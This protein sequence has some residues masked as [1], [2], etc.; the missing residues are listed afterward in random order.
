[1]L[2]NKKAQPP[3]KVQTKAKE[4]SLKKPSP[5]D[6]K[7]YIDYLCKEGLKYVQIKDEEEAAQIQALLREEVSKVLKSFDTQQDQPEKSPRHEE[8][9]ISKAILTESCTN[10]FQQKSVENLQNETINSSMYSFENYH[11]FSR[12]KPH[13]VMK[14]GRDLSK[15]N[16]KEIKLRNQSDIPKSPKFS[17]EKMTPTKGKIVAKKS[18]ETP[19]NGI[20]QTARGHLTFRGPEGI[21]KRSCGRTA[22]WEDENSDF[23][24]Q[25]QSSVGNGYLSKYKTPVLPSKGTD[26]LEESFEKIPKKEAQEKMVLRDE[27]ETSKSPN[28][29]FELP[30]NNKSQIEGISLPP[31]EMNIQF[32]SARMRDYF[33]KKCAMMT[34]AHKNDLS[35]PRSLNSQL[36]LAYK[37]D[38]SFV[39]SEDLEIKH[40]PMNVSLEH[41]ITVHDDINRKT[42]VTE[43]QAV[44]AKD[45][46]HEN[47]VEKGKIVCKSTC[48]NS[49]VSSLAMLQEKDSF[50][51]KS[52][53]EDFLTSSFDGKKYLT[54][55]ESNPA[56][57]TLTKKNGSLSNFGVFIKN[58]INK[59]ME[60]P[61]EEDIQEE[62]KV[63]SE[64]K[65]KEM[66]HLTLYDKVLN[67]NRTVDSL[68]RFESNGSQDQEI[69]F[70]ENT[71]QSFEQKFFKKYR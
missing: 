56:L 36:E 34:E 67:S 7:A 14:K 8:N 12:A 51:V 39:P 21:Q 22:T 24:L 20:S 10:N 61:G 33:A 41:D 65:V 58:Q 48:H 35:T 28:L 60:I 29:S 27:R 30:K 42:S 3:S 69:T 16:R 15:E 47:E 5:K 55:N 6:E 57:T 9:K 66:N 45:F 63:P 40:E 37:G 2:I 64:S 49:Q 68:W 23:S 4:N 19:V 53:E 52:Q 44:K 11:T 32:K 50:S 59:L 38:I 31:C 25:T 70:G 17:V 54:S 71:S 43:D 62:N 1:M 46:N 26:Y 13:Q 18:T